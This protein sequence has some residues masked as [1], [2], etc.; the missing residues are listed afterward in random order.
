[1]MEYA[2]VLW[3]QGKFDE[4]NRVRTQAEKIRKNVREEFSIGSG[5]QVIK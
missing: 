3:E 1:M 5:S 4:S 2:T